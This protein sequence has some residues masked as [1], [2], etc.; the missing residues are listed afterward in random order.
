MLEFRGN[1]R[2]DSIEE[3]LQL[4]SWIYVCDVGKHL[5]FLFELIFQESVMDSNHSFDVDSTYIVFC[6]ILNLESRLD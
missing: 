3:I 6:Q 5:H 1:I 2:I 4:L